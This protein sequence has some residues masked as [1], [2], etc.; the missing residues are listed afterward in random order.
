MEYR[1]FCHL[2]Y[3]YGRASLT[4]NDVIPVFHFQGVDVP[5]FVN[6]AIVYVHI[7]AKLPGRV[8]HK[9]RHF[10]IKRNT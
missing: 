4:D 1:C 10:I 8:A 6:A 7:N 2:L 9:L 5:A 3:G